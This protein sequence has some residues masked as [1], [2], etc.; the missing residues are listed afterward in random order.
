MTSPFDWSAAFAD[1]GIALVGTAAGALLAF[2]IER[3]GRSEEVIEQRVTAGNLAIFTLRRA[4]E[5]LDDYRRRFIEPIRDVP[6]RWYHLSANLMADEGVKVNFDSLSF[7]FEL[8]EPELPLQI[9]S[10][11][12]RCTSIRKNVAIRAKKIAFEVGPKIFERFKV[13]DSP[14]PEEMERAAGEMLYS[15][16]KDITD[17]II[18]QVDK[19]SLGLETVAEK[20]TATLKKNFP[21][22]TVVSFWKDGAVRE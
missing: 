5:E 4:W 18:E 8:S 3:R 11:T 20:L 7:L 10:Y 13:G 2:W 22:R 12:E 16:T 15:Q 14:S 1:L 9:W 17:K 19:T 21:N 6:N